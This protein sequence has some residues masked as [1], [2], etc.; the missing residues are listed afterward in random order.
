MW[1]AADPGLGGG[2][3]CAAFAQQ[4]ADGGFSPPVPGGYVTPPPGGYGTPPTGYSAPAVTTTPTGLQ[5]TQQELEYYQQLFGF[6]DPEGRGV[7]EGLACANFLYGSGLQQDIL[8][9]IWDISDRHK[10][11]FLNAEG[12]F[13]ALRLVAHAQAGRAPDPQLVNVEP[14]ALPDFPSLQRKRAP[15]ELS[16]PPGSA[17]ASVCGGAGGS[18]FS[19]LQPVIAGEEDEVRRAAAL[20]ARRASRSASPK[21]FTRERWAPTRRER[22][23]YA[24]LFVRTDWDGDGFVQ[25]DQAQGLLERSRLSRE[26]LMLAWEHADRGHDGRLDFPEFVC[27]VHIV[28]CVL[29]GAQ[30][31]GPAEELP[32]ELT[33]ALAALEPLDVLVAEREASRSRSASPL[34]SR[35]DSPEFP[36]RSPRDRGRTGWGQEPAGQGSFAALAFEDGRSTGAQGFPAPESEQAPGAMDAF[37]FE[38]QNDAF[39]SDAFGFGPAPL[40]DDKQ[41]KPKKEKRKSSRSR[42]KTGGEEEELGQAAGTEAAPGFG[43]Q[44][45]DV[46]FGDGFGGGLQDPFTTALPSAADDFLGRR[47]TAP[48]PELGLAR[49]QQLEEAAGHFEAVATA[50]REVS[51]TLRREVDDLDLELRRAQDAHAQ[52]ER[53]VQLEQEEGGRLE[54]ER[55]RLEAAVRQARQ[56]LAELQ[57]ERKSASLESLSLR[58]DRGHFV[59]ETAFLRR[60]STDEDGTLEVLQTANVFLERSQKELEA[61]TAL[62]ERER[63]DV[64]RVAAKEKE[65]VQQ[66]E[67][68]NAELRNRLERFR[69]EHAAAAA[70][71]RE[72]SLREERVRDMQSHGTQPRSTPDG[73]P[74]EPTPST[75]KHTWANGLLGGAAGSPAAAP[76]SKMGGSAS[77]GPGV[78]QTAPPRVA[79]SREGV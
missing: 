47:E 14:P 58:R 18:E 64:L 71:R 49:R 68:Q 42:K 79:V 74:L 6:A 2:L 31:P 50:D 62:L 41:D 29:R 23:K 69:R 67:R 53:Q 44:A 10:Q 77:A 38:A 75:G 33:S 65:L 19:E 30:L 78:F 7:L 57:D 55:R 45:G 9:R 66:A 25:G 11:G 3:G 1:A 36:P 37:G 52:L 15:S 26:Q 63:R 43:A 16:P 39:G 76:A 5:L 56:R 24:S 70:E 12:F 20:A 72:V 21:P 17:T 13:V 34:A 28:T 8:H 4:G 59:E 46:G 35:R 73:R 48:E 61:Q 22:R 54:S 51:K 32:I 40:D 60:M 27:L